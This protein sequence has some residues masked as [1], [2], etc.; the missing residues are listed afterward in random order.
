MN[1]FSFI[2][3]FALSIV[4]LV[5]I[6]VLCFMH[7]EEL[8]AVPMTN[9][10]K[11]AHSV[12]FLALSGTIFFDNTRYLRRLISR[13]RV[14]FGSFLLP[15]AIGG[16]IEVMQEQ[17]TRHRSGDWYDFLFDAFGAVLGVLIALLINRFL[18]PK[19]GG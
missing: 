4:L 8:P 11:L 5:V 12:M 14:F 15:I 6:F 17:F 13:R 18:K 9:F 3:K 16:A 7:T 19:R 10:D 2:R 1:P